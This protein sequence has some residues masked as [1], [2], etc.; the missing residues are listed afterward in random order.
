MKVQGAKILLPST[1]DTSCTA[2][3][4]TIENATNPRRLA[5]LLDL[6]SNQKECRAPLIDRNMDTLRV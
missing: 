6:N 5:P 1:A 2:V 4:Y 3:N